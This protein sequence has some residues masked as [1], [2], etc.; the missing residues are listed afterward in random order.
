MM[1]FYQLNLIQKFDKTEIESDGKF[2]WIT[3]DS[4]WMNDHSYVF[5]HYQKSNSLNEEALHFLIRKIEK[6]KVVNYSYI[7][8]KD[9]RDRLIYN[10]EVHEKENNF[11]LE[12]I[13]DTL[14]DMNTFE[15]ENQFF[16][17]IKKIILL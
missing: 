14:V 17:K 2:S 11:I 9:N 8:E 15:N 4:I 10:E 1:N 13:D 7:I 5:I 16:E 6:N 12:S 3:Y